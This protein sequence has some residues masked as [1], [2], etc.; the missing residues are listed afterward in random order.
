[1]KLKNLNA[2]EIL[3]SRGNPTVE[4]KAILEDGTMGVGL[5]PSGAST[6]THEAL[7]LRDGD[8]NRYGGKGVLKACEN[9][10][11]KIF[12]VLVGQDVSDH[13]EVDKIMIDLDGTENKSKLG[14]NAILGTSLAIFNAVAKS[15][16]LEPYEYVKENFEKIGGSTEY[17]LPYPLMNIVNGGA[18]ADSGLDIQEY[19]VIPQAETFAERIRQGAEIFHNLGKILKQAGYQTTVGDEGGYAPSLENN[20]QAWGYIMEAIEKAGYK[21]GEDV[22]LA[23]DAAATEFYNKE[24]NSYYFKAQGKTL[25]AEQLVQMYADWAEKYPFLS[26]EDPLSEDDFE[27]WQ[28]VTEKLGN[29]IQIVGDDLFVTN[30]KRLDIGIEKKLA[31]SIL[32]KLNQIGSV[33]ET[34]QCIKKALDADFKCII[35]HRSGETTDTFISD[36]AVGTGAGFIKTGS[37]S[38]GERIAKYNRLMEIENRLRSGK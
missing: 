15:K 24:S 8:D 31:N 18:H 16:G 6:G 5:V 10:N 26:M 27:G 23:I 2:R 4:V 19:M 20:D 11:T 38:R 28:K 9:V 14:A 36:L 12:E 17:I 30:M 1:M 22:K 7:E 33:I 34:L 32:I 35:S 37:L 13:T 29:K 3:D 25:N 21:A